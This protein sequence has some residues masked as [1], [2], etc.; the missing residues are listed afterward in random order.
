MTLQPITP[1]LARRIIAREERDGDRWH[2]EY[3]FDD[4]LVPLRMLAQNH[5]PD[6]VFTLYMIRE[7]GL[8]IG[9]LGFFG[10][11]DET[12][13]V[14]FGYGLIAAARG[15]GLASDAVVEGLRIAASHGARR[16]IADTEVVNG[17]SI[18]VLQKA[19]FAET[20]RT[21]QKVHFAKDLQHGL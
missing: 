14:E 6:P 9:G 18:R 20:E 2:A 4:E 3:P 7:K 5:A 1:D 13:T 19:G 10:P 16:A 15:R 8:A 21:F 11:P 12:D 17:A